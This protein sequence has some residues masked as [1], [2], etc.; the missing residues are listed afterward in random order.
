MNDTR[1]YPK[2]WL[3]TAF[4]AAGMLLLIGSA[5][6]AAQ[7][8]GL[9]SGWNLVSFSVVPVDPTV[10][11]VF[12]PLTDASKLV[13]VWSYDEATGT[14]STFPAINGVPLL[15]TIEPGRGYWVQVTSTTTLFVEA[16][17]GL[18]PSG[19]AQLFPGWNLVGFPLDSETSYE[20]VLR[21]LPITNIWRFNTFAGGIFEGIEL[22]GGVP[23]FEPD[24]TQIEGGQGYWVEL[25]APDPISIEPLLATA[26]R[27]DTDQPPVLTF[28][29]GERPVFDPKT[30]GDIDVGE[31]GFYDRPDFQ[32]ALAFIDNSDVRIVRMSNP[33]GGVLNWVATV[34]NPEATP[35]LTFRELDPETG[36]ETTFLSRSGATTTESD[37]VDVLVDRTS[38]GPG[39]YFGSI[40]LDSSGTGTCPDPNEPLDG[41]GDDF[42]FE[43]CRRIPVTMRVADV[44][45][46]YQLRAEID[47][48]NGTPADLPNPRLFFSL[49]R[50]DDGIDGTRDDGRVKGVID[51]QRT[52]L[53]PRT[54]RMDGRV[55]QKGTAQFIVSGTFEIPGRDPNDPNDPR[56]NPYTVPIRRDI[57]LIGERRD[58]NNPDDDLLGPLDLKGSYLETIRGVLPEPIVLS[59]SFQALRLN[60]VPTS[61]DNF[62][63]RTGVQVPI[64]DAPEEGG[65]VG[66]IVREITIDPNDPDGN[67]VLTD[68]DVVLDISHTRETDLTV[69]LT[70]PLGGS[71][72]VVLRRNISGDVNQEVIYDTNAVPAE[73]LSIFGGV[74]TT[75]TWTLTIEDDMPGET[76][77]LNAWA[78]TFRGTRISEL[79]GAVRDETATPVIGATVVLSGCGTLRT[80]T[81]GADGRY[82][83]PGLVDCLYQVVLDESGYEQDSVEV[84]IAGADVA[85]ADLVAVVTAP[86]EPIVVRMPEECPPG[87][88][89]F[90]PNSPDPN[91]P[92][93]LGCTGGPS[94]RVVSLTLL[95]SAGALLPRF[96]L[97]TARDS[98][99]FDV[100]RPPF[101]NVGEEDTR[102]FGPLENA[103]TKTNELN[104]EG[105]P[106][107]CDEDGGDC[108]EGFDYP[109]SCRHLELLPDTSI[110]GLRFDPSGTPDRSGI[111]GAN[112]TRAFVA[113]GG[114][115]VGQSDAWDQHLA[116]GANP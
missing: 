36:E 24:F 68:I 39:E 86:D 29:A 115:I 88:R 59:G 110:D 94:I 69:T 85:G 60:D 104:C 91:D 74:V 18:L 73:P 16:D 106:G 75:G 84:R 35:W 56:E 116:I 52:L 33:G 51:A 80:T 37:S 109:S 32:R 12:R 76:G 40:L 102:A 8:L 4:A 61:I 34:E 65:G 53:F 89:E 58:R 92:E 70:S 78:L 95:S 28:E 30:P 45:A 55:Y 21:D 63:V 81:T 67:L 96:Q 48:V 57:T 107:I 66:T 19:P 1:R 83:F 17:P 14:W 6:Q 10:E 71:S 82:A 5:A 2:R 23:L 49:Y 97:A 111:V 98:A 54:V 62:E 42:P 50:D 47:T 64:A 90:D 13:A 93:Y 44:D 103:L 22:A 27:G 100:D 3:A 43:P 7:E 112:A 15:T 41:V 105:D 99:T 77:T 9:R 114:L 26:M 20:S 72:Q 113:L 87:Q 25:D 46:D 108:V 38:L 31:D 79:G 11:E 101:G